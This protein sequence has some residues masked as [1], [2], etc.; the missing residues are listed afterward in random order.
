MYYSISHKKC[1]DH[2][3]NLNQNV[4]FSDNITLI[5]LPIGIQVWGCFADKII[6]YMSLT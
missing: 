3:D 2:G 5:R 6:I 1:I 4:K